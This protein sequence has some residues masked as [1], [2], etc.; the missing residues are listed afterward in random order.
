M[1]YGEAPG[2]RAELVRRLLSDGYVSSAQVAADLGV[3]EM[4]IRRDLRQLH[5]DGV[6]IRVTGG[7][8][9]A[10]GAAPF[11]DRDRAGSGEKRAIAAACAEL[12]AGASTVALDAGTTVAPLAELLE[13]G[14]TVVSH[15]EPVLAR[16]T[17]R[18]DLDVHALG[19]HYLPQ[20]RAYYGPLAAGSL[21]RFSLD[22]AVLSA[23]AVDGYGAVC[24]TAA[25]AD[26]KRAL[27]ANAR[28][29][30]LAVHSSKLGGSAMHRVVPLERIDVLVTDA[31]AP[32][33]EV[34][35][36]REAGVAVVLAPASMR[37]AS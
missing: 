10:S 1:R 27:V 3:S 13:P 24:S 12:L 21:E 34:E 28:R 8:R 15:S 35:R 6:A 4:T 26:L 18:G 17:A 5:L 37:D 19:G 11:E 2:R 9:L 14:V 36:I 16:A 25:D 32:A 33:P 23:T 20:A 31:A 7:A 22:A 30:I 29:V